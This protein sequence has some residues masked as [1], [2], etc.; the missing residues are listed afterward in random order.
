MAHWHSIL[1]E[2]VFSCRHSQL[3][4]TENPSDMTKNKAIDS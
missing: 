1:F 3:E 2:N 4:M